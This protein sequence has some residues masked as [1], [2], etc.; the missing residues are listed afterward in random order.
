MISF[1]VKKKKVHKNKDCVTQ[2]VYLGN[3]YIFI[4]MYF[5]KYE[6]SPGQVGL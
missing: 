4:F 5:Y 3:I 1:T 6:V 2:F